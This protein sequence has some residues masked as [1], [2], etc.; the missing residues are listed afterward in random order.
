M[1]D[2]GLAI[3]IRSDI[4][5]RRRKNIKS[6]IVESIVYEVILNKSRWCFLLAY[7]PPSFNNDCFF[8]SLGKVLDK[9][10]THYDHF[11]VIGDLNCDMLSETKSKPLKDFCDSYNLS[12]II[13]EPTC[14][15]KNCNPS[16]LD[17]ILR[18]SRSLCMTVL[19]FTTGVGDCHKMISCILLI[20]NSVPKIE[21]Q[22]YYHRNFTNFDAEQ[23][24]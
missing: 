20:L 5:T 13:Q 8:D 15:M 6:N 3:Y 14:F 7:N 21:K 18:N 22:K 16:L 19:N 11:A 10:I 12:K 24:I 17:I 23:F 2:G 9:C 4:A 1:H